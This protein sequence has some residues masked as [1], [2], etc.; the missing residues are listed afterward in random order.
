MEK[1]STEEQAG[2]QLAQRDIDLQETLSKV[3][4]VISVSIDPIGLIFAPEGVRQGYAQRKREER[5]K[6]EKNYE[7]KQETKYASQ[8]KKKK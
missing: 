1:R 6:Q 4:G 7:E 3:P 5:E 8:S 2:R